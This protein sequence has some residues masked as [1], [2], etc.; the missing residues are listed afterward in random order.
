MRA[1]LLAVAVL[2]ALFPASI[3]ALPSGAAAAPASC[4]RACLN[5]LV[6]QYLAAMVAHDPARLPL[7]KSVKFTED[8]VRLKP[9]D[10]LWATASGVG[11]YKLYFDEPGNGGAGVFAVVQE[12]GTPA[13]LALRLK[14]V[15]RQITEIETLVARKQTTAFLNTDALTE[16]RPI[17]L[18]AIP[19]ADRL[20][21]QEMISIVNK[22]FEGIEQSSGDI[23]PF[24]KDC[25]R[26]ENGIQTT[27]VTSTSTARLP[28]AGGFNLL[29]LGCRDQFNTKIFSYIQTVSPRRFP[30]VDSE[31]GLVLAMVRFNHPGTAQ[32]IEVPGHGKVSMGK[33]SQW[34]NSTAI[35]ELFK[36][37]DGKIREIT[38][39]IVTEAYKAPTGWE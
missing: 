34:P 22:Y 20:S 10:G 33:Y 11:S 9:G 35:A 19:P 13:L 28:G 36:V 12:N 24:D 6:D 16:P 32:S 17:F 7:A 18:E 37:K 39:V 5:G 23:V 30:I 4:D 27:N 2:G 15:R 26:I 25:I 21:R 29:A 31:R 1:P 38:A 8:G 3:A 14:V